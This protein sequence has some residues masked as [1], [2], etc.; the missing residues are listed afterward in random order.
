MI[1][2]IVLNDV[3]EHLEKQEL[4]DLLDAA[5]NAL[6]EGGTLFIKVPNMANPYTGA[7]SFALDFT[8][9]LVFTE[10]SLRQVL[11]ATDFSDITIIGADIYVK[12]NI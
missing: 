10:I 7:T 12:K 11:L 8:H 6:T 9:Q 5:R 3:I 1:A 4:F 2:L